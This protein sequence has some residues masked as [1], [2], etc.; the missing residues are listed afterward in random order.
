M[1]Q[2]E[3]FLALVR[4]GLW[5]E[6]VRL[7]SVDNIDFAGIRRM[8][9][10][11]SVVGLVT[12]GLE[13]LPAGKL[14]LTEKLKF[15]GLCQLIEQRNEAM[16]LLSK[17]L[18]KK[19]QEVGIRVLLVKGQGLAQCYENPLWRA[20]GDIDLLFNGNDFNKAVDLLKPLA[21]NSKPERKYSKEIGFYLG[22]ILLELHGTLRTGLSSR[23]DKTVDAVQEDTFKNNNIR[24]WHNGETSMLLPSSDNDVFF[25]FTHFIKHF[26]KEGMK[27][28]QICDWCR[29]LWTYKQE[30]DSTL[31]TERLCN[32]GLM[33]EWKVFAALSV[34]YL[35]MPI[36]AMPLY[37][38]DIHLHKKG[39]KVLGFILKNGKTNK[40]KTTMAIA[41]VFPYNTLCFAPSIFMDV[42]RMKIKERLLGK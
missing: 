17:V 41:R 6:E 8:A 1:S 40:L 31:L 19:L 39:E 30:I 36:E 29:V 16:N 26:Y 15:A 25:V 28:R 2:Q 13:K 27:L 18:L 3:A 11:Q 23:I 34:G 37:D 5:N 35:G 12:A 42:N 32:A 22:D 24:V 21:Q 7:E 14:P 4:A 38:G 10:D 20:S 33:S 9:E